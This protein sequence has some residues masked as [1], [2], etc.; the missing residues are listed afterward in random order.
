MTHQ[1]QHSAAGD[2]IELNAWDAV[3]TVSP[4]LGTPRPSNRGVAQQIQEVLARLDVTVVG[5]ETA[6]LK[7]VP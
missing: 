7:A 1:V 6:D 4:R 5:F 2:G 3:L